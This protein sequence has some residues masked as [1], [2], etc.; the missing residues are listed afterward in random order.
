LE[1]LYAVTGAIGHQGWWAIGG[2]QW[3][4][5]RADDRPDVTR[6][7]GMATERF[8]QQRD[9][10][11]VLHHQL[12]P[13]VVAIGAMISAVAP[14]EMH[15]GRVGLLGTVVVAIDV[16]PRAVQMREPRG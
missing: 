6:V 1:V 4:D 10:C 7:A 12:Q 8:H 9:P 13:H 16:E 3:R 14:C 2:R 11:L 5:V 15:A